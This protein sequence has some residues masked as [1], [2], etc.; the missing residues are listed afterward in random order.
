M[1]GFK[2]LALSPRESVFGHLTWPK[3]VPENSQ[4]FPFLKLDTQS[5]SYSQNL[6]FLARK[7]F[8]MAEAHEAI[9]TD[10][11]NILAVMSVL[12]TQDYTALIP[13]PIRTFWR[14]I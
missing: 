14:K 3:A 5:E 1:R 12:F 10:W 13:E 9:Q 6:G 8:T 2:R 11:Q 7:G 4:F